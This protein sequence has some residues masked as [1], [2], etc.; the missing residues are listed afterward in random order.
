MTLEPY[1][2]PISLVPNYITSIFN[3]NINSSITT[4]FLISFVIIIISFFINK[5]IKLIPSN[6]QSFFEIL[7]EYFYNQCVLSFRSENKAKN[8]L[9][10]II[11]IF[12]LISISNQFSIIPLLQDV[13]IN[14]VNVFTTPT[15]H[16]SHTLALGFIVIIFSHLVAFYINPIKHINS[17]INFNKIFNIKSFKDIPN[18][19]LQLFLGLLNLVGEISKII[20]LSARLFGNIFAGQ[21][22]VSVIV[23]LSY[24]TMFIVPIPFII[25]STFSGIVQG[26]VFSFLAISFIGGNIKEE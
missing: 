16:F 5:N 14:K 7:I 20:S 8:I 1:I 25:L 26:F 15:A 9:P 11:T 6:L 17:I 18:S 3:V 19:I 21:V 23:G 2:K 12:L 4:T 13:I 22:I 24:Y 10:F